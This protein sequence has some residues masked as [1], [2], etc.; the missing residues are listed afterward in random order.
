[1]WV[2]RF[3]PQPF[4]LRRKSSCIYSW[5]PL[6]DSTD[7]ALQCKADASPASAVQSHPTSNVN[8]EM[9]VSRCS[10]FWAGKQHI[11]I[12]VYADVSGEFIGPI[13]KGRAVQEECREQVAEGL[14]RALCELRNNSEDRSPHPHDGESL[15]SRMNINTSKTNILPNYLRSSVYLTEDSLCPLRLR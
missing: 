10:L 15:R 2:V 4:Y 5:S 9:T 7:A 14:C 13:F 8:C 3:T 1:M 6:R 11:L 12:A